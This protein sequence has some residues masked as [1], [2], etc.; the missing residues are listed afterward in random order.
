VIQKLVK[1]KNSIMKIINALNE[2][3]NNETIKTNK[4]KYL[5]LTNQIYQKLIDVMNKI[6]RKMIENYIHI[7]ERKILRKSNERNLNENE[8]TE[9]TFKTESIVTFKKVNRKVLFSYN[10]LL[11]SLNTPNFS[12][13]LDDFIN[14]LNDLYINS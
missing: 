1:K 4:I 6:I 8:N 2:K 3:S 7:I 13:N 14:L 10:V 11:D 5:Q 12:K 9:F